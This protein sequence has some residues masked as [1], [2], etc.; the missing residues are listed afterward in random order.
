MKPEYKK[1]LKLCYMDT[2]SFICHIKTEDFFKDISDDVHKRFDTSNYAT[3]LNRLLLIG[4]NGK[5]LD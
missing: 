4:K 2:D 1:K 3:T 5:K